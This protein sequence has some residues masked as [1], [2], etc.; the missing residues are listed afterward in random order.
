MLP[1]SVPVPVAPDEVPPLDEPEVSPDVAPPVDEPEVPPEGEVDVPLGDVDVPPEVAPPEVPPGVVLPVPPVPLDG[2]DGVA[3][4]VCVDSDGGVDVAGADELGVLLL[5][6]PVVPPPCSLLLPPPPR[7]HAAMLSVSRLSTIRVREACSFGFI[8]VPFYQ[9]P[10]TKCRWL[11][12]SPRSTDTTARRRNDAGGVLSEALRMKSSPSVLTWGCCIS[13]NTFGS[14]LRRS[15]RNP[16]VHPRSHRDI[17][18]PRA[19]S[20]D[21]GQSKDH[22]MPQI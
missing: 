21:V 1:V 2:D 20:F 12:A 4:G 9:V 18:P 6:P 7:L 15:K 17:A 11:R 8:A 5:V 16:E 14:G 13:F 19:H 3:P 10:L 22:C